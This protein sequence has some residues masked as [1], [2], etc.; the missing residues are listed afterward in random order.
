MSSAVKT[1]KNEL[2]FV[3]VEGGVDSRGW[4]GRSSGRA[5]FSSVRILPASRL[6]VIYQSVGM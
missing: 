6:D 4:V 2:L 5:G 3:E 1:P